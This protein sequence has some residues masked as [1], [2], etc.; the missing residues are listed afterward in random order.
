MVTNTQDESAWE[1][2]QRQLERYVHERNEA[3]AEREEARE[4]ADECL[5]DLA[6][7][8]DERD[9]ARAE[10]NAL[11]RQWGAV[12]DASGIVPRMEDADGSIMTDALCGLL[13]GAAEVERLRARVAELEAMTAV[14]D[15]QRQRAKRAEAA[16]EAIEFD[17]D[18]EAM[19]RLRGVPSG[20]VIDKVE[21][22]LA[23]QAELEAARPST[24]EPLTGEQAQ[25]LMREGEQVARDFKARMRGEWT[26]A[27]E[28]VM[29]AA[30]AERELVDLAKPPFYPLALGQRWV[31]AVDGAELPQDY[32]RTI[33]FCRAGVI[34]ARSD[35]DEAL[36]IAPASWAEADFRAKHP[37]LRR[38]DELA[39]LGGTDPVQSTRGERT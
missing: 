11:L 26:D 14:A 32:D 28:R 29:A 18:D 5:G 24:E 6:A 10:Y 19:R 4:Y 16:L 9:E 33:I 13:R 3:R 25:G 36:V 21:R 12:V 35:G 34:T 22:L 38:P 23:E 7:L 30:K 1:D 39:P 17:L 37:R 27:A 2:A 15:A 8:A 31:S 20:G